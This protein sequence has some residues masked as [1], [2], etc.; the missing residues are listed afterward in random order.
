MIQRIQSLYLFVALVLNILI[1]FFPFAEVSVAGGAVCNISHNGFLSPEGQF[2]STY[3][4]T[5]LISVISILTLVSIFAFKVRLLQMRLCMYNIILSISV[6]G[7][8]VYYTKFVLGNIELVDPK[9][10]FAFPLI[11]IVLYILAWRSVRND[12]NLIKSVDRI[13]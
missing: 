3:V 10:S 2:T 5:A 9:I 1:Y 7:L 8:M 12:D 13:R 6:F 11:S 4:V